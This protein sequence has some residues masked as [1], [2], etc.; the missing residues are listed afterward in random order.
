MRSIS[1]R[2]WFWLGKLCWL[3]KKTTID[4]WVLLGVND[5]WGLKDGRNVPVC[6]GTPNK[7]REITG[8]MPNVGT[9]LSVALDFAMIGMDVGLEISVMHFV[10]QWTGHLSPSR[11]IY[12]YN[13]EYL[14]IHCKS[15]IVQTVAAAVL[16]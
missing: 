11:S 13:E 2:A 4:F 6:G 15:T 7:L 3:K 1:M 12:K 8:K 9:D 10:S 14:Q 5:G 16:A